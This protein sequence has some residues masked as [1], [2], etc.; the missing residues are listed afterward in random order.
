MVIATAS[1]N[2]IAYVRSLGGVGVID[3]RA[4]RFE[5]KVKEVDAVIDT[6]GGEVLDRSYGVVKRGGIV[7]SAAAVPSREKAEQH[8]V[9]ATF[10]MVQVTAER[11]RNI[12]EL[13]DAGGLKTEVGEVL[14]LDEARQA[15]EML[16]GAAHRRGKIVIKTQRG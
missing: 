13:I 15:H 2:D 14:W 7:V 1:A 4:S 16:E 5:E 3:Y 9:R 12:A 10:F 8:R 6:V 11:L